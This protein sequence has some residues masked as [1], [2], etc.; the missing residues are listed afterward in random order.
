MWFEMEQKCDS[1]GHILVL[2]QLPQGEGSHWKWDGKRRERKINDLGLRHRVWLHETLER[3]VGSMSATAGICAIRCYHWAP[4][5]GA[6]VRVSRAWTLLVCS[7]SLSLG[8]CYDRLCFLPA[9]SL[10]QNMNDSGIWR[11]KVFL[12]QIKKTKSNG[13]IYNEKLNSS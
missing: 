8:Q 3:S 10:F 4:Q 2:E 13:R 9:L 6:W 7:L 11:E 12:I 5:N 1:S